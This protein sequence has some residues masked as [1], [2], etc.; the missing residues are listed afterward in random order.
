MSTVFNSLSDSSALPSSQVFGSCLPQTQ[1]RHFSTSSSNQ[2]FGGSLPQT[3]WSDPTVGSGLE[4]KG[5]RN[6]FSIDSILST[7]KEPEIMM[8][9]GP[10]EVERKEN[11]PERLMPKS[12]TRSLKKKCK[13]FLPRRGGYVIRHESI[14]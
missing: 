2:L 4:G 5:G 1:S 8:K 10:A 7:E 3:L 12:R 11:E 6:T 9:S 13:Q 14:I